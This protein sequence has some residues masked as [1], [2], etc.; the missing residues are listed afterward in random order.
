[1]MRFQFRTAS[2]PQPYHWNW[3]KHR[4]VRQARI[5]ALEYLIVD[6]KP[7]RGLALTIGPWQFACAWKVENCVD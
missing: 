4:T 5:F 3:D 7:A 2:R 6:E 1:M